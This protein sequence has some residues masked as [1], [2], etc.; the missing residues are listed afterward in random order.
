[1]YISHYA[2]YTGQIEVCE[3]HLVFSEVPIKNNV[4]FTINWQIPYSHLNKM[5]TRFFG[6]DVASNK[7]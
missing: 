4:S 7:L 5:V 1:M 2:A 3:P 6:S